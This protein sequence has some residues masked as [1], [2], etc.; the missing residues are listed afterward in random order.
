MEY[1]RKGNQEKKISLS[2]YQQKDVVALSK[3]LLG[4]ILFTHFNGI[5]TAGMIVET[6]AYKG[7]EDKACHAYQNRKTARTEV[8]FEP[9]GVAYVYLC[10]GIHNLFN[11]VT[12]TKNVPHAV[13]IRAIEPACG[14]T[15]MLKRR[16]KKMLTRS[17]TAGPGSLTKALGIRVEHSGISLTSSVIWIEDHGYNFLDEEIIASPRVG[18][19]YAQEH[20]AL[21]LRFR[22]KNNSWTSIAK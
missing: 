7:A 22:L 3:K 2:F 10:Y 1:F 11:I 6:E 12:H 4:K 8:M 5:L 13:L 18:V 9:G 14:I 15:T 17:L 16:K 20:A 21:P 19:A